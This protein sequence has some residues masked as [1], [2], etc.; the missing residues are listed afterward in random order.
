M[1]PFTEALTWLNAKG[2]KKPLTHSIKFWIKTQ[3]IREPFSTGDLLSLKLKTPRKPSTHLMKSCSLNLGTP[4]PSIEKEPVLQFWV[5]LK[6]P[7]KPTKVHL[8]FLLISLK[9]GI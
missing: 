5:N 4:M 1:K 6:K 8:K 7:L 3:L 9:P 2:T